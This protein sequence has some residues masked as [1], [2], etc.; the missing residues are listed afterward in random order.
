MFQRG[1]GAEVWPAIGRGLEAPDPG[2]GFVAAKTWLRI[3]S[4]KLKN[5]SAAYPAKKAKPPAL[6]LNPP[7]NPDDPGTEPE[8]LMNKPTTRPA[9]API[10]KPVNVKTRS[11]GAS[12]LSRILSWIERIVATRVPSR[13][14]IMGRIKVLKTEITEAIV[15]PSVRLACSSAAKAPLSDVAVV[16]CPPA[17]SPVL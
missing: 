4:R 12:R 7:V 11:R 5:A 2:G 13:P 9:I 16:F 8:G 17:R 6:R 15:W 3:E 14:N 10:G 1:G